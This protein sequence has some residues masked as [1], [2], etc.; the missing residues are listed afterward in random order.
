MTSGNCLWV[1]MALRKL[2]IPTVKVSPS[3][4]FS[5]HGIIRTNQENE[6]IS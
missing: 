6:A 2:K 1:E 4:S 5:F 3:K